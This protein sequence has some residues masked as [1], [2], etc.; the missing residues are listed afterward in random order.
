M[1]IR[2]SD[3]NCL[4]ISQIFL[5]IIMDFLDMICF[6]KTCGWL[7][8]VGVLLF[9]FHAATC[10]FRARS[11]GL[12]EIRAKGEIRI[13]YAVEPPYA[14]LTEGGEV[15]G[16]SPE[17]AKRV[18][19]RLG[20]PR[21]EWRL[22][23]FSSL[24]EELEQGKIDVIATGMFITKE[25]QKRLI[26]S[27]PTCR[28]EQG[29]L[30]RKGNPENLHSYQDLLAKPRVTVAVIGGSVEERLMK[31]AG[32]PGERIHHVPDALAGL[33]AVESG[34][35]DALALSAPTLRWMSQDGKFPNVEMA[36]SFHP[37]MGGESP[38]EVGFGFRKEDASLRDC[39]NK[40]Q[41]DYIGSPHHKAMLKSFG[42]V[43]AEIP[44]PLNAVKTESPP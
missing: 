39:W 9:A 27:S 44:A 3:R 19:H 32:M 15:T 23:E 22:T 7:A 5:N 2:S 24:Q 38:G 31:E 14:F 6:R 40:A 16:E 4:V 42:F 20:L 33:S 35:A 26:F 12:D 13:G 17:V 10:F 30:V 29:L 25:R 21:I 8:G 18:V 43:D 28:V 1:F 36:D 41:R 11:C 34:K 37:G